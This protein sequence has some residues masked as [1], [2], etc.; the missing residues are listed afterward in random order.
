MKRPG[1]SS[2][3]AQR[4]DAY[5]NLLAR[6][7]KLKPVVTAV[8]YPCEKTALTG[9]I[10]AAEQKLIEPILVGPRDKIRQIAREAGLKIDRY[11]IDDVPEPHAAAARAVEIIRKA[12]AQVLMKGSLH[13]D[14]LLGAVVSSATGLR[15]SRR[16]SHALAFHAARPA[17]FAKKNS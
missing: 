16:L 4:H 11:Q 6:C 3:P 8:A 5:E 9:A 1:T 7:A 12:Q 13:T 14:E 17:V 15:T 10:E 2:N